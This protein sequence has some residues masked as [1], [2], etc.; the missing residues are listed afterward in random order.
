MKD[1]VG[2]DH[3]LQLQFSQL[4]KLVSVNSCL[5]LLFLAI[6]QMLPTWKVLER[7]L[8]KYRVYCDQV[9]GLHGPIQNSL[10]PIKESVEI[11]LPTEEQPSTE[12]LTTWKNNKLLRYFCSLNMEYAMFNHFKT[13][14]DAANGS[15]RLLYEGKLS[16]QIKLK[17]KHLKG[18]R[19]THIDDWILAF[20]VF[21]EGRNIY[22][23]RGRDSLVKWCKGTEHDPS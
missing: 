14:E 8:E 4:F 1:V 13:M 23:Y 2:D 3:V 17:S 5:M 11:F 12:E 20:D 9:M 7:V 16:L 18:D 15:S 21:L 6:L 10:E 19:I 22:R